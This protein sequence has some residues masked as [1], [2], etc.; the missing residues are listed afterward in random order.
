MSAYEVFLFGHLLCVIAWV[1]TDIGIQFLSLRALADGGS[2]TVALMRDVEWLGQ[3]LLIPV[4]L[5]AGVF[6]A[7]L[8]GEVD[9]YD[10]G[11]LWIVL[12][13]AGFGFSFLLGAGFLG[14][15]TGRIGK[16]VDER[17]EDDEEVQRRV[18]RVLAFSRFELLVLIAIVLDMVTKPGL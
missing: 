14:P 8:V 11:D 16:L 17:G 15:E 7:L 9:H 3:R 18:R 5:G 13:L 4:A 2:R 6:G 10:W 1:G 12:A